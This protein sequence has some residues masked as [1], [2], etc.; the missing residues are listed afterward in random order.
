MIVHIYESDASYS[1]SFESDGDKVDGPKVELVGIPCKHA[2]SCMQLLT[3][4]PETYANTCYTVTTRLN[5]YNH[6]INL[7]KG[8]MQWEH[9]RDMEP[10]LPAMIRRP[11]GR[12]KQT[13]RKEVDEAR[14]SGPKLSK[15]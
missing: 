11:P 14:K 4:N 10:I 9:V 8:L 2:I 6:L 5:I 12:P 3:V 7:V 1:D 13:K 15:T